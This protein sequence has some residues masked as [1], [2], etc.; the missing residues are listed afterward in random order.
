[1]WP[2]SV[3]GEHKPTLHSQRDEQKRMIEDDADRGLEV[4]LLDDAAHGE[5]NQRQPLH[6]RQRLVEKD[7]RSTSV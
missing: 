2:A 7:L 3:L 5:E 6:A 1:V 4:V